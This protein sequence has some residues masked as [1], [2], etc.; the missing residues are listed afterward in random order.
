MLHC[1]P[2]QSV[3]LR[4]V[5]LCRKRVSAHRHTLTSLC[6]RKDVALHSIPFPFR[7]SPWLYRANPR[8]S[9]P[10][11]LQYSPRPFACLQGLRLLLLSMRESRLTYGNH[12]LLKVR[13]HSRYFHRLAEVRN[14]KPMPLDVGRDRQGHHLFI[15]RH[16]PITAHPP[17]R[18]AQSGRFGRSVFGRWLVGR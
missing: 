8:P 9:I 17:W 1:F 11:A 3:Q 13:Q 10:T 6:W 12:R 15:P 7:V 5:V 14:E 16:S 4:S 2:H 18:W